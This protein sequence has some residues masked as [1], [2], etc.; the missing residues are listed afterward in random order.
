MPTSAKTSFT[1]KETMI[2]IDY[3]IVWTLEKLG[4]A[5]DVKRPSQKMVDKGIIE[6]VVRPKN[7]R[8]KESSKNGTEDIEDKNDKGSSQNKAA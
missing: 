3:L 6:G 5:W 1:P 8:I 7:Y 4:L 2:D